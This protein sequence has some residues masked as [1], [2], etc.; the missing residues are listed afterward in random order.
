LRVYFPTT[1]AEASTLLLEL[2]DTAGVYAG[3]VTLVPLIRDQASPLTALVDIKGLSRLGGVD[4]TAA[5]VRIGAAVSHAAL[6]GHPLL[7]ARLPM[8]AEAEARLGNPRVRT[9]GTIGGNICFADP[10][11]D[12]VAPLL[13]YD[14]EVVLTGVGG[15]RRLG[16]AEFLADPFRVALRPGEILAEIVA[17][18][19]D[20]R[21]RQSYQRVERFGRPVA[22]A[23][24]ALRTSGGVLAAVRL[25]VGCAGQ[26]PRRLREWEA[27]LAG[28]TVEAAR[29][30][31]ASADRYLAHQIEPRTDLFGSAGYKLHL[32]RVVLDRGLA[33]E[34][35]DP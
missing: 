20:E 24:V 2:G 25:A 8:L 32:A 1:T 34:A 26:R 16:L 11:S 28:A 33:V 5:G 15:E 27:R 17:R 9:Q 7:R 21:W 6:A 14:A 4:V 29:A 35:G 3:G 22:T 30:E 13:V 23:A 31:L 12:P 19:L 18:P 10:V